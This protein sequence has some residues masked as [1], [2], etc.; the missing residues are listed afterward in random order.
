MQKRLLL[1]VSLIILCSKSYG[2]VKSAQS[3]FKESL[4]YASK[5][6]YVSENKEMDLSKIF[7]RGDKLFELGEYQE[8]KECFE[9]VMKKFL[10]GSLDD[11]VVNGYVWDA[12][13]LED[14]MQKI[15]ESSRSSCVEGKK[16]DF[17]SSVSGPSDMVLDDGWSM[18]LKLFH[19]NYVDYKDLGE[20]ISS[21]F[22][23]E[24]YPRIRGYKMLKLFFE[25]M[26]RLTDRAEEC[27]CLLE[28][29]NQYWEER[30]QYN[31]EKEE[32]DL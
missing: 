1:F 14:Y 24:K 32:D 29:D 5:R 15:D 26:K 22:S 28:R 7:E 23:A 18:F 21:T 16:I 27:L 9:I 19:S 2:M 17:D 13:E 8:A 4:N 25:R 30:D 12:Y 3:V 6:F 10:D 20:A 31:K 11:L